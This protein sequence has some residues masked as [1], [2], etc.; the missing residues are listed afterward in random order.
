MLLEGESR[1]HL[2]SRDSVSRAG[3]GPRQDGASLLPTRVRCVAPARIARQTQLG[4][5]HAAADALSATS[6]WLRTSRVTGVA[7]VASE[8]VLLMA[9]LPT[10]SE[11]SRFPASISHCFSYHRA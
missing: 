6:A 10:C 4:I 7:V 1:C 3:E 9:Q 8:P 2:R 11:P 5:S